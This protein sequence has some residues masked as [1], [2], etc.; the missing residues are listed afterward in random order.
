MKLCAKE[1]LIRLLSMQHLFIII[2]YILGEQLYRIYL[3]LAPAS[4]LIGN[5]LLFGSRVNL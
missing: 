4:L 3:A 1:N 2:P 5:K